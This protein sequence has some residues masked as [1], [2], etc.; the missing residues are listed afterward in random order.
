M[1][2]QELF[3][4]STRLTTDPCLLNRSQKIIEK[5]SGANNKIKYIFKMYC[6][7]MLTLFPQFVLSTTSAHTIVLFH[8]GKYFN[9]VNFSTIE[10]VSIDLGS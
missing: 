1:S 6:C 9:T 2:D 8:F 7:A 10:E 5:I 3:I 4:N